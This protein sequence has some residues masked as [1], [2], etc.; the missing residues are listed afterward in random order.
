MWL[1]ERRQIT[2][3]IQL[4]RVVELRSQEQCL[5]FTNVG[6]LLSALFL[7]LTSFV[8]CAICKACLWTADLIFRNIDLFANHRSGAER[9][10]FVICP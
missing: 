6:L 1:G 10:L 7:R 5:L 8:L 4:Q 3:I 2:T 9:E